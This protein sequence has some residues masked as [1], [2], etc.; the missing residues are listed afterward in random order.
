MTTPLSVDDVL[1]MDRDKLMAQM[2]LVQPDWFIRLASFQALESYALAS[3]PG[4]PPGLK[5]V[6]H[7]TRLLKLSTFARI[8]DT[9]WIVGHSALSVQS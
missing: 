4:W 5:D 8:K 1:Q 9:L 6:D 7:A 3:R 2:D